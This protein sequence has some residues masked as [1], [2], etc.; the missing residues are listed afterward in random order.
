MTPVAHAKVEDVNMW[1][2]HIDSPRVRARLEALES[3][4]EI[5]LEVDDIIGRWCRMKTGRDGRKSDGLRP[6]GPMR[7]VWMRWFHE[8]KGKVVT[9]RP[10]TMADDV[11]ASASALMVEWT[12]PEDEAAFAGL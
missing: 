7:D 5:S 8:E 2:S 9:V 12:S 11:A 3:E 4:E 1:F 6:I 10:V